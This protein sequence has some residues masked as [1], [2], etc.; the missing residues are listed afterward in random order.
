VIW[1][2]NVPHLHPE[3]SLT[4]QARGLRRRMREK[5]GEAKAR[6]IWAS[7]G[8]TPRGR[9][10][11]KPVYDVSPLIALFDA[12]SKRPETEGW[13]R[14]EIA[15]SAAGFAHDE[16]PGRYG[17]TVAAITKHLTRELNARDERDVKQRA[18]WARWCDGTGPSGPGSGL[19]TTPLTPLAATLLGV[20]KKTG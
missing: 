13:T 3:A 4:E 9:I 7:V 5:L 15:R 8:K 16:H 2:S 14:E 20:D 6:Q 12:I 1:P 11:D 19:P 10:P 17:S 18:N